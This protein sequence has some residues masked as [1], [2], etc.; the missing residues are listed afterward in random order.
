MKYITFTLA[1]AAL[2][3]F[4]QTPIT[5]DVGAC[6]G[7]LLQPIQND[8]MVWEFWVEPFT[9]FEDA[10]MEQRFTFHGE[11]PDFQEYETGSRYTEYSTAER[12][13]H[14]LVL[15]NF[16]TDE[17]YAYVTIVIGVHTDDV[18][19]GTYQKIRVYNSNDEFATW[20]PFQENKVDGIYAQG[21]LN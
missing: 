8:S 12:G 16:I 5:F 14:H 17:L 19:G 21:L 11:E 1:M 15:K 13:I 7:S 3:A 6:R 10:S 20:A 9:Y 2:T 18:Y 4:G